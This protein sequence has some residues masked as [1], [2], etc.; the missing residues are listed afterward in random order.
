M[1]AAKTKENLTKAAP[2][3]ARFDTALTARNR[4][5]VSQLLAELEGL[6]T[7]DPRMTGLR[8]KA[9]ALPWPKEM[10]HIPAIICRL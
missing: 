1:S 9:D 4:F 10:T 2:V 6:I 8:Q 7:S 5:A 3:L